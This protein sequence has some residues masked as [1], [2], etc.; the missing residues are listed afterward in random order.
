M[1]EDI[2]IADVGYIECQATIQTLAALIATSPALE[3]LDEFITRANRALGVGPV[4]HPSEFRAGADK[5]TE[6]LAHACALR[7]ARK[8]IREASGL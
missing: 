3:D 5:L 4:F 7:T 2:T 1:S 6:V 8:L